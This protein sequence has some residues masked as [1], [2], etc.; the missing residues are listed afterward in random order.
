FSCGDEGRCR[1]HGATQTCAQVIGDAGSDVD[2]PIGC[3][4]D[5]DSCNDGNPCTVSDT[6]EGGTC[7]G[8]AKCTTAPANA[9]PTCAADGTCGFACHMGYVVSGGACV[10]VPHKRIFVTFESYMGGDLG[11]LAGADDICHGLASAANL[12]GTF[13]AWLSDS[14]TN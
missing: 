7:T 10:A 2:G 13:M 4:Q 3:A 9:D 12:S 11:G 1:A 6:C 5:G 8:M 14:K